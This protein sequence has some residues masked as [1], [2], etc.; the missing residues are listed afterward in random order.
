MRRNDAGVRYL[1]AGLGGAG[2]SAFFAFCRVV[3]FLL[4]RRMILCRTGDNL[5][6]KRLARGQGSV[7]SMK[8]G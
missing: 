6:G 2:V 7:N 5:P 8:K 3:R 4:L 1:S